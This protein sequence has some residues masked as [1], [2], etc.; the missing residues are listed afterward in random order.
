MTDAPLLDDDGFVVEETGVGDHADHQPAPDLRQDIHVT[1]PLADR[2]DQILGEVRTSSFSDAGLLTMDT[3][4][5]VR[6][7]D[8]AEFQLTVKRSR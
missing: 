8:G 6:L 4:V 3:G 1:T 2:I 7:A 5:V